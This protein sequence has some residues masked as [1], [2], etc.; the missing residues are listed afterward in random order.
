MA[1]SRTVA[2][3]A[4]TEAFYRDGLGF[5][6]STGPEPIPVALLDA[7][8][9]AGATGQRLRMRLG[10]QSIA[11]LAFDQPGLPYP[12]ASVATDPWFQHAAIVVRDME[13]AYRHLVAVAPTPITRGG[14]QVLPPSS[15]SVAAYKFRDPDGHPLELIAFPQGPSA[16]RWA[17]AP[18]LFLGIDHSAI[19]VTDRDAAIA[20]FRDGLGLSVATRGL[21]HGPEQAALDGLNSPLVDV[22][23]LEPAG[24]ATPHVEL[25]QYRAPLRRTGSAPRFCAR[26]R[27][28]TRF[29]FAVDG[30]AD[31]VAHLRRAYPTTLVTV[32]RDGDVAGLDGPDGHGLI[33]VEAPAPDR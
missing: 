12:A 30:L 7:L 14:P 2:D 26:D 3:L 6:R 33:L 27:A 22:I 28:T 9:L 18:G 32:S 1:I 5:V 10:R 11:F 19:T 25:L 17:D 13:A 24:T 20:F 31:L 4:R 21:N 15:G 23:G 29:V 8:G 16:D